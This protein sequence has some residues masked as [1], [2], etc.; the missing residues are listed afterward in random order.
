MAPV[1]VPFFLPTSWFVKCLGRPEVAQ[2][3]V[4]IRIEE[5]VAWLR[6][7]MNDISLVQ[8]LECYDLW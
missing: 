3:D 7:P 4:A 8:R 6:V 5:N 2:T 1:V